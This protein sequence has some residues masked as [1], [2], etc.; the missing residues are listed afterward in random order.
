MNTTKLK[1]TEKKHVGRP[2]LPPNRQRTEKVLVRL[3]KKELAKISREVT[4]EHLAKTIRDYAIKHTESH[5]NNDV[6]LPIKTTRK[7]DR[8]LELLSWQIF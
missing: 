2:T 7:T 1:P 5:K 4:N 8:V 3:S 6:T